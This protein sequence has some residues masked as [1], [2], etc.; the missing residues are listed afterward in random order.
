MPNPNYSIAHKLKNSLIQI[1]RWL[2]SDPS[3]ALRKF[4][5][6]GEFRSY[7]WLRLL[8]PELVQIR[9]YTR[10]DR[11]PELFRFVQQYTNKNKHLRILSFGCSSGA[12]VVTLRNYF[13]D[14]EIVGCD[15]NK[16]NLILSKERINDAKISYIE[17]TPKNLAK[18]G[19][20]DLIFCLAVL[21]NDRTCRDDVDDCSSYFPFSQFSRNIENL[22][23]VLSPGGLMVLFV[24]NFRFMDAQVSKFYEVIKIDTQFVKQETSNLVVPQYDRNNKRIRGEVYLD[25]VFQK[26]ENSS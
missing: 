4:I 21:V 5:K 2:S 10:E 8:E 20:F 6:D 1:K 24:T 22:D 9:G 18:A 19:P 25:M 14:A 16:K 17:S 23:S 7:V 3:T 11:Y 15:I 12:E 26:K 13:P